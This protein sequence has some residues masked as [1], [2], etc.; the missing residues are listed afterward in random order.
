MNIY[1]PDNIKPP[2]TCNHM[3]L[4]VCNYIDMSA[5][6]EG[7]DMNREK[8]TQA[9]REELSSLPTHGAKLY[10]L[11][12]AG[13]SHSTDVKIEFVGDRS[14]TALQSLKMIQRLASL[15]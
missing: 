4:R 2:Y 1:E 14:H 13:T 3:S 7:T 6:A 5:Y 8:T 10:T 15:V 11:S 9:E 12:S